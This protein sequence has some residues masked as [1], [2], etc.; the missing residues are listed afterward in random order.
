LLHYSI[1]I[2]IQKTSQMNQYGIYKDIAELQEKYNNAKV[3]G[4]RGTLADYNGEIN[5]PKSYHFF[6]FERIED[7]DQIILG[8]T[9]SVYINATYTKYVLVL[10]RKIKN[11]TNEV[12]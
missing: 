6:T 11:E 1:S 9:I 7:P 12:I 3:A 2:H 8:Q 5:I 10:N 4:E